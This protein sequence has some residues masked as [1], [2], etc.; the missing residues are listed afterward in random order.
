MLWGIAVHI[1]TFVGGLFLGF[2]IRPYF[3]G[4]FGE[5]GKIQAQKSL[6]AKS[7]EDKSKLMK[8]LW[9]YLK[10]G[11]SSFLTTE[12]LN[13]RVFNGKG[14]LDYIYKLLDELCKEDKVCKSVDLSTKYPDK[15]EWH[16]KS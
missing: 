12:E 5:L 1:V 4:Y 10:E 6:T 3:E 15:V 7:D 14:D 13:R 11:N 16:C 2:V 9:D 8:Y